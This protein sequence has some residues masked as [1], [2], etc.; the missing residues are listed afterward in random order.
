MWSPFTQTY[1]IIFLLDVQDIPF[2]PFQTSYKSRVFDPYENVKVP[3]VF[4]A[5]EISGTVQPLMR[6]H[7]LVDSGTE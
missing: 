5:T 4:L 3:A 2:L 1:Y 6:A 7:C